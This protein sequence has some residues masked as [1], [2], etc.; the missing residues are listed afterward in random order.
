MLFKTVLE[1]KEKLIEQIPYLVMQIEIDEEQVQN[2]KQEMTRVRDK[3][4]K[5]KNS[6]NQN[7]YVKNMLELERMRLDELFYSSLL[8]LENIFKE[9]GKA[10]NI[11]LAVEKTLLGFQT[12]FYAQFKAFK[13]SLSEEVAL[14]T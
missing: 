7:L 9:G 11:K 4:Q 8:N 6:N 10:V 1:K 12:E 13:D 3:N 2:F 5:A 14:G